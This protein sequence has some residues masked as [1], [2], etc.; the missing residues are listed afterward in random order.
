[1]TTMH[2][3]LETIVIRPARPEDERALTRLAALDSA[4]ALQGEVL[5]AD[6][7]GDV[8][9]ALA[10]EQD[11]AV[12]DPFRPTADLVELLRT[13]ARL[14]GIPGS[15]NRRRRLSLRRPSPAVAL[16]RP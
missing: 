13:R 2:T 4:A 16:A 9:A 8:V 10:V 15:T 14:M 6:V 1:M 3:T 5:V 7:E 11:R 12:A